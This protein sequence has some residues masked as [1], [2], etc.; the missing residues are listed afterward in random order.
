MFKVLN[1]VFSKEPGLQADQP[2]VHPFY[3]E[4]FCRLNNIQD[5]KYSQDHDDQEYPDYN[6]RFLVP[7]L[8]EAADGYT[9]DIVRFFDI[10]TTEEY[11]HPAPEYLLMHE[12][13]IKRVNPL[14]VKGMGPLAF[15]FGLQLANSMAI[16]ERALICC[17]DL[18]VPLNQRQDYSKERTACAFIIEKCDDS[19]RKPGVYIA[20]F[21]DSLS[22]AQIKDYAD[23]HH[24]SVSLQTGCLSEALEEID[25]YM[26]TGHPFELFIGLHEKQMFGC[27]HFLRVM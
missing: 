26:K 14:G 6:R 10:R 18:P 25:K 4:G 12:I 9:N 17:A 11:C 27:L 19:Y 3:K 21:Q 22:E 8:N 23:K 7:I 15:P 13:G 16:G 1:F 20:E 2:L 24:F 5:E